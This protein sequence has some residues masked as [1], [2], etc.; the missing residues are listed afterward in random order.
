[1]AEVL[2]SKIKAAVF[3]VTVDNEADIRDWLEQFQRAHRRCREAFDDLVGLTRD[4]PLIQL[5]INRQADDD[6]EQYDGSPTERTDG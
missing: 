3:S 2:P 6:P 4:V 5:T 1:M